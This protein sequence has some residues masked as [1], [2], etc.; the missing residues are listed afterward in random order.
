MNVV[1]DTVNFIRRRGLKHRQFQEFLKAVEAD[2][3]DVVYYSHVRWL[4]R[5][6]VLYRF[7]C[8]R[9]EIDLFMKS[10]GRTVLSLNSNEW[11]WKL[12]FLTDITST[13]NE[14][15]LKLQGKDILITR[16]YGY[17]KAFNNKLT[18]LFAQISKANFT[19]FKCCSILQK[20]LPSVEHFPSE[21]ATAVVTSLQQ[22]FK[23]R[24]SDFERISV[25]LC[26]LTNPFN[27]CVES[28]SSNVQLE[29]IDLQADEYLKSQLNQ[30]DLISFYKDLSETEYPRL[31]DLARRYFTMFAS[32][33]TCEQ[34]F[35]RLNYIKCSHRSR[36]S[37]E[38]LHALLRCATSGLECDIKKLARAKQAHPS[39]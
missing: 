1:T 19:H 10:I 32:K 33:Y 34:T 30:T 7:F 24:F 29:L 39:H 35:S 26:L 8:L 13:L 36:L 38:H 11:L 25:D 20:E 4:S 16:L 5:G 37:D 9:K 12:A 28:A 31:R 23:R 3:G 2:Y 14:L 17:V 6:K 18:F 27:F 15:N 21:F 22:E